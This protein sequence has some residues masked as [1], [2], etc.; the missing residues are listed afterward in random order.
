MPEDPSTAVPDIFDIPATH[1]SSNPNSQAHHHAHK[2]HKPHDTHTAH[3][4]PSAHASHG[5]HGAHGTNPTG[6]W[7]SVDNPTP[8][9]TT[10]DYSRMREAALRDAVNASLDSPVVQTPAVDYPDDDND[11]ENPSAWYG[12]TLGFVAAHVF[13]DLVARLLCPRFAIFLKEGAWL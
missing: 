5:S 7:D 8:A 6:T 12:L 4:T 2:P 9:N 10:L 3:T 13:C 1:T 11:N